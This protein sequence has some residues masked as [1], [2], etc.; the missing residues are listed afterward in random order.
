M[1]VLHNTQGQDCS[2]HINIKSAPHLLPLCP[3]LSDCDI[4]PPPPVPLCSILSQS[5]WQKTW[6]SVVLRFYVLNTAPR[7]KLHESLSSSKF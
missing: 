7:R 2:W 4:H 1:E 6:S 5:R 3:S